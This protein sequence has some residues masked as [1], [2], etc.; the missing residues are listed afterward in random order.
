MQ[1]SKLFLSPELR[2]VYAVIVGEESLHRC[3]TCPESSDKVTPGL[4]VFDLYGRG[5][6]VVIEKA[7]LAFGLLFLFVRRQRG[8][9]RLVGEPD[10]F[11]HQ[12]VTL[13]GQLDINSRRVI[14][15]QQYR[16]EYERGSERA[17]DYSDLLRARRAPTRKPV[18]RSCEVVPPFEAAMQTMP[19]IDRAVTKYGAS[20]QPMTKKT[21]QVRSSVAT[22]MPE[23]GFDEEPISPVRRDET[24]TNKKP[25]AMIRTAPRTFH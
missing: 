13:A 20:V 22:V 5:C 8:E 19:P 7:V 2:S 1:P 21:R 9:G 16:P 6:R 14:Q 11:Y 23:M 24:V 18:L 15:A 12:L 25:K 4:K 10:I 3:V 17:D